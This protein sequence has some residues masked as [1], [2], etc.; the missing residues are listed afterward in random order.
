[1]STTHLL[2]RHLTR[3]VYSESIQE[4]IMELRMKP[5]EDDRQHCNEFALKIRP[6]VDLF[7]YTDTWGNTVHHFN[8][9]Q[10][11]N[12]LEITSELKV[13][14]REP[15]ALPSDLPHSAWQQIDEVANSDFWH[16]VHNSQFAMQTERLKSFSAELA[17]ERTDDPL[18]TLRNLNTAI[19]NAFSYDQA[20]TKVD[21][22]I[23]IALAARGGVCQDFAH[24]M[25]ALVR[26]LG[27]PCR[28]VSGY[29]ARQLNESSDERSAEDES[30]AWVEAWLP[31]LGWIGFD[32]TNNLI[33]EGRHVRVA[34]GRDYADVPP[35]RGV[36]TG[37]AETELSVGVYVGETDA[38]APDSAELLPTMTWQ[39]SEPRPDSL[40][41]A[42]QQ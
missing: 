35:T 42:Q 30:H 1:M 26:G 23:D 17:L 38:P 24:I 37:G 34:V 10:P 18:T 40:W 20:Q 21:S 14:L 3:F 32:P 5:L 16:F 7:S 31:D 4:N 25:I 19:F 33:D 36:F 8:I 6:K 9:P 2:I 13:A 12:R 27:I 39:A 41:Q 11:H 22:P 28:Y 29:L 15:P